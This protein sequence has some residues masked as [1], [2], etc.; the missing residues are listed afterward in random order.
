[1]PQ[2]RRRGFTLIELLVVIAII[3]ILIALLL[4]AVQQARE[5][6]RRSD[7][8]SKMKQLGIALHN[9]HDTHSTLPPGGL[10]GGNQLSMQV[11][12]LAQLEQANLYED[13][14]WTTNNYESHDGVLAAQRPGVYL[15]PSGT[16]VNSTSN[17]A[18]QT[19]HYYGV[20]GGR[21]TSGTGNNLF[22]SD[23]CFFSNS[24]VAFRD[25]TDGLSNTFF[26]GEMS[27]TRDSGGTA[28]D[29]YRRWHRGCESNTCQGCKAITT[30]G[31]NAEEYNGSD[32]F[33]V[34]SFGSNHTGGAQF[35]MGDG[36]VRFVSE[37]VN[38]TVY[39]NTATRDGGETNTVS[40]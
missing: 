29:G 14:V 25:V 35:V 28:H 5:A 34:M 21:V 24:N 1:M 4:P 22:A 8:K 18:H 26:M 15:C 13:V 27:L 11:R 19:T 17:S 33:T 16:I 32:N 31:I 40:N 20:Q 6:A 37:N 39:Q 9:Y 3:A 36:A 30:N 12:I 23:G 2:I 10:T 7:C 38:F